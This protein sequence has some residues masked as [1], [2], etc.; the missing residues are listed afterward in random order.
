ME[1]TFSNWH[2]PPDNNPQPRK[3]VIQYIAL[4]GTLLVM[5]IPIGFVLLHIA[6]CA[7]EYYFQA[8]E[9]RRRRDERRARHS[10][11]EQHQQQREQDLERSF[12]GGNG[13]GYGDWYYSGA[14]ESSHLL[15]A[16]NERSLSDID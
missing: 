10:G 12:V 6:L 13:P 15:S 9:R 8:W 2:G 16:A 7:D 11:Q 3:T 4:A 14:T 1:T 5:M